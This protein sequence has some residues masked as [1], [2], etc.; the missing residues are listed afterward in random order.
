MAS[1]C[2]TT[3]ACHIHTT[4]PREFTRYVRIKHVY[5]IDDG[6][7]VAER[8]NIAFAFEALNTTSVLSLY[9]TGSIPM[10]LVVLLTI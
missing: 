7:I 3:V 1:V 6:C 5:L 4:R 9:S 10:H 8:P 2:N